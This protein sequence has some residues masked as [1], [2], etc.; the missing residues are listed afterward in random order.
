MRATDQLTDA[1]IRNAAPAAKP[2]KM[3]DGRGLYQL[4]IPNGSRWWRFDYRCAGNPFLTRVL[5]GEHLVLMGS[6]ND[7]A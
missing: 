1:A 7:P 2:V 5:E 3:T 6:E 4:L